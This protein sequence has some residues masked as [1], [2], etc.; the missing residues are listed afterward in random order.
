MRPDVERRTVL[1]MSD[2]QPNIFYPQS[3]PI[4]SAENDRSTDE[5]EEGKVKAQS[6]EEQE[7]ESQ[8][9][10]RRWI[11]K[12]GLGVIMTAAAATAA[13]FGG[14]AAVDLW[15][16][17]KRRNTNPNALL[18]KEQAQTEKDIDSR[19]ISHWSAPSVADFRVG[20]ITDSSPTDLILPDTRDKIQLLKDGGEIMW[21]Q[22]ASEIPTGIL[23]RHDEYRNHTGVGPP[24][25]KVPR[26]QVRMETG[27][28]E[29][30]Y[31]PNQPDPG[32]GLPIVILERMARSEQE[33]PSLRHI[34]I[35]MID[36]L[37]GVTFELFDLVQRQ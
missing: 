24:I 32:V 20:P 22:A 3:Q 15:N 8:I 11:I 25:I 33:T 21:R 29:D 12:S 28:T 36:S 34:G 27:T 26:L 13:A 6:A 14:V 4:D 7:P 2:P 37:G 5:D 17:F 16:R 23:T 30:L 1:S 19:R 10:S 18:L 31:L 9:G 35:R